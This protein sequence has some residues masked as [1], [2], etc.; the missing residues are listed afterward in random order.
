MASAD[1][2]TIISKGKAGHGSTPHLAVDAGVV[3][4]DTNH[5]K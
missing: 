4:R 2:G 5:N 3:A 1:Y